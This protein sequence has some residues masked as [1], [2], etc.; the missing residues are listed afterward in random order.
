MQVTNPTAGA[1]AVA[2]G[3]TITGAGTA[4][5]PFVSHILSN[6]VTLTSAQILALNATPVT[7]VPAPAAGM[8]IV[9]IG[10]YVQY[11]FNTIAYTGGDRLFFFYAGAGNTGVAPE[12]DGLVTAPASS[13]HGFS[14]GA[15][16][17][18]GHLGDDTASAI[19]VQGI[20]YAAG[21]GTLKIVTYYQIVPVP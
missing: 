1:A 2:D 3:V 17:G 16:V 10:I 8:I 15:S 21:N 7:I 20:A 4:G 19:L 14:A 6:T 18:V 5:S 9:P 12:L 13:S 11:N